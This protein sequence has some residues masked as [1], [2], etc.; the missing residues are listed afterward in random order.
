MDLNLVENDKDASFRVRRIPTWTLLKTVFTQDDFRQHK[1]TLVEICTRIINPLMDIILAI[2]C[3]LI[4][5]KSS[6]LRRRASFAPA[7]AVL[8]MAAVM[9]FYMSM[10]NMVTSLTDV[11]LLSIGVI[12]LLLLLIGLLLKK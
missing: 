1:L 6:L 7:M 11:G 10:S 9:A 2:V 3:T 5:L 8:G 4:L 12:G